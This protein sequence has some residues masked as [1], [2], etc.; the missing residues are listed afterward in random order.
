MFRLAIG[1]D[2]ELRFLEERHVEE[3]FALVDRH[4]A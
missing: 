4:R 1:D 3:L 2:I